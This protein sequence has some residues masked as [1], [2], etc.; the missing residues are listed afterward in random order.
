MAPISTRIFSTPKPIAAPLGFTAALERLAWMAGS[1]FALAVLWQ[2]IAVYVQNKYLP[3]PIAVFDVLWRESASGDLWI[4]TSATL[5]RVAVAFVVSM[6]IGTAIGLALG[7]F[8]TADKFF[9][10]WLIL[11]LNLPA[12]VTITLCYIWFGLTDIAAITAVALNKIPNVAVNMREG[13]R[14]LSKDLD[15]MA[16]IYKFGWWKT[17][18]H[19][20]LPQLAPFFAA[21]ARSGLSLVWKIVLVVEAFG[22]SSGVGYRLSIAFQE[23]DVSTILAYALAFILIV[24]AIEFLLLQPLQARVSA[25]R[26]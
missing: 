5:A 12:L 24:Q 3:T 20:T 19:V 15:E 18:R 8:K 1:L 10:A 23:F 14:S 7:R 21:S 17:L 11:F 25:W 2:L 13:A 4:N 16:K 22:R 26:R 9:D 6:F